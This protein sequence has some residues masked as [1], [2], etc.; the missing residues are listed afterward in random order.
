MKSDWVP[1]LHERLLWQF[2]SAGR[3]VDSCNARAWWKP[4]TWP[5][6][7]PGNFDAW[8]AFN[9]AGVPGDEDVIVFFSMR[10]KGEQVSLTLDT[11]TGEGHVLSEGPILEVWWEDFQQDWPAYLANYLYAVDLYMPE[12]HDILRSRIC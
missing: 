11:S 8:V 9:R 2:E 10:R 12:V 1:I 7:E 5:E 3:L 6:T 4:G